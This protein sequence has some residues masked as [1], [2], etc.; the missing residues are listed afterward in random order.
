M[1]LKDL[2][3]KIHS[4]IFTILRPSYWL[5]NH[6]YNGDWDK[7][8]NYLLDNCTFTDTD[9]YT[10]KLS[11]VEIWI[12]NHPYA[13]FREYL[14]LVKQVRPSRLTIH[15]AWEKLKKERRI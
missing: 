7:K 14:C 5:M 8:L 3:V 12:E 11:G 9:R 6:P 10:A 15:K 1:N 2:K 4:I 13:S